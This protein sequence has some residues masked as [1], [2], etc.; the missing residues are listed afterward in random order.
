MQ[1]TLKTTTKKQLKNNDKTTMVEDHL[2]IL[3][4]QKKNFQNYLAFST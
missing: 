4:D 2:K 1:L 3:Q